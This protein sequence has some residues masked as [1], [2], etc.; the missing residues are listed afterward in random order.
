MAPDPQ[1]TPDAE[2][3][4]EPR[5]EPADLIGERPPARPPT[6]PAGEPTA[7]EQ[8]DRRDVLKLGAAVG[9]GLLLA[10]AVGLGRDL[11]SPRPRRRIRAPGELPFSG[12]ILGEDDG[13]GHLLRDGKL[14]GRT[15]TR[16]ERHD[17]L[18]IGAGIAGLAAGWRLRRGDVEAA[19]GAGAVTVLDLAARPG[20]NSR[21]D[22]G[23][24]CAYPWGAHYVRPPT[25]DAR[26]VTTFFEEAGII[27]GRDRTGRPDFDARAVCA[28]PMERLFEDGFWTAGLFPERTADAKDRRQ[29]AAFEARI[30]QL[31]ARRDAQGRR[32]FAIPVDASCRDAD[33]VALDG[34]SFAAWLD[35]EGLTSPALRWLLE[36]GCRDDYGTSLAT[37]SAWAGLHYHAARRTETRDL[38]AGVYLR[39]P[40]GNGRLVSLLIEEGRLDVRGRQLAFALEPETDDGRAAALV[41][42][43]AAEEIVRHEAAAIVFAGPRFVLSRLLPAPLPGAGAFTYAPWLVAN[44]HLR[45][46]PRGVGVPLAWDNVLLES[47]SLGYVVATHGRRPADGPTVLTY[48]RPFPHTDPAEARRALLARGWADWAD[49]IVTDLETAHPGIAADITRLDLWR[50]GHAMVR[51]VPGFIWGAERA[52]AAAPIGRIRH[53][54]SDLSG[55]SLFEEALTRGVAAAEAVLADLGHDVESIR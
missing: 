30:A 8:L 46:P 44:L 16:T 7:P 54:H 25:A 5:A 36:Y 1:M 39:W 23:E 14:A 15:A 43:V 27:R 51:P 12:A 17:V 38:D 6:S 11:V 26:A 47:E 10:G 2:L 34:T 19:G 21:W 45:R 31:A 3:P 20:G 53:A 28:A 41:Y 24:V 49:E 50:W 42:D 55:I 48:Y 4:A 52:A 35:A 37:T 22:E 40:E 18:I 32:A 9:G 29:L 13:V 33:L